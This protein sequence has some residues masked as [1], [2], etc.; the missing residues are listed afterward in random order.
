[1]LSEAIVAVAYRSPIAI[2]G[3]QDEMLVWDVIDVCPDLCFIS[4]SVKKLSIFDGLADRPQQVEP[5]LRL[6]VDIDLD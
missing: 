1:V 3:A 4:L 6:N 5:D 2:T